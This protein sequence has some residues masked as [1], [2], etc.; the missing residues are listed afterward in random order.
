MANKTKITDE[1]RDK[2]YFTIIPNYILN[3]STMWDR[4]VYTQMKRIAGETGTCWTS[5]KTLAKQCGMSI[6][7][8]KKSLTYLIEHKWIKFVGYKLAGS[9]GGKQETKEYTIVDLWDLNMKFYQDQQGVSNDDTP[10]PKGV[11]RT[12]PKGCHEKSKGVS[13]SD[14]KEEPLNNITTKKREKKSLRQLLSYLQEIPFE[15]MQQF[16]AKY[17]VSRGNI[18]NKADGLYNYCLAHGKT[19]KDYKAVLRNALNSDFGLK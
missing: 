19:Y 15:D 6:N 14:D 9:K 12:N 2:L 3:H 10:C 7:R 1:S 5:Q 18:K 8:L 16:K 4:E 17:D 13:P 11:S